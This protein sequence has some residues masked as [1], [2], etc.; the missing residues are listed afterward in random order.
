MLIASRVIDRHS[1]LSGLTS[2]DHSQYVHTTIQRTVTSCPIFSSNGY[3]QAMILKRIVGQTA[4]LLN[5]YDEG[6]GLLASL[7]KDGNWTAASFTGSIASSN[8]TGTI[9]SARLP[10]SVVYT[11]S[12]NTFTVGNQKITIDDNTKKGLTIKAAALQGVNNFEIVDSS[13]VNIFSIG[14][15]GAVILRTD[16]LANLFTIRNSANTTYIKF[17]NSNNDT[18]PQGRLTLYSGSSQKLSLYTDGTDNFLRSDGSLKFNIDGTVR[19]IL[20]SSGTFYAATLDD[21]GAGI[22]YSN[23]NFT[24]NGSLVANT[25]SVGTTTINGT[26]TA[27]N[28]YVVSI[29]GSTISITDQVAATTLSYV[30][31]TGVFTAPHFAGDGASLTGII[32]TQTG[33]NGK[34][35]TTNGSAL[36]WGTVT[37]NPGTVTSVSVVSANGFAGTVATDTSTPAITLSTSITGILKGNG[38]AISAASSGSDYE[39]PITFSTGL[40]RTINTVAVNTSQNIATLSNLTSDG[41]VKTSSSNGTLT[42]DASTYLTANQSITLSG[43]ASGSGS[44]SISVTLDNASVIGKVLTGYTSGAGT[45]AATDTILQAI[46]KLNGNNYETIAITFDGGGSVL[47]GA[48]TIYR[49]VQSAG[50]IVGWTLLADQLGS[51][52]ITVKSCTYENFPTTGSITGANDPTLSSV[53]KNTDSTLT[54]WTPAIT[55]DDILEFAISGTPVSVTKAT[56]LLK[57]R[58]A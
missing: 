49:Q 19:A 4:N 51:L 13:D 31:Y 23:T 52:V 43:Q 28:A 1:E 9:D 35:L 40:T 15:K 42:I 11:T 34:F 36:S 41:F 30:P 26:D 53:Q 14:S 2:D 37:S 50:T 18:T 57:V 45:V 22:L 25:L 38:T 33:N 5:I 27:D 24:V 12:S 20:D 47:S 55:T 21:V 3:G 39:V 48:S 17:D 6:I 16:S 7:D 54:S 46:Q 32:P 56:L 44:T 10:T 29:G 58:R 8:L